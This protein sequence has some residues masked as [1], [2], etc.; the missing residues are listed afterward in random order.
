MA[1]TTLELRQTWT[2]G[3]VEYSEAFQWESNHLATDGRRTPPELLDYKCLADDD[4]VS[5]VRPHEAT[6][7]VAPEDGCRGAFFRTWRELCIL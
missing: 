3:C 4:V 5:L 1:R 2:E 6:A 7:S